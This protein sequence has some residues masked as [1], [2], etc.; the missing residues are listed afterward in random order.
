MDT[1]VRA[2]HLENRDRLLELWEHSA[3]ATHHVL[4]EGDVVAL[5][6][7]VAAEVASDVLARSPTDAGGR[8]LLVGH[9]RRPVPGTRNG[10]PLLPARRASRRACGKR[11]V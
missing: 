11:A 10:P 4:A 7:L 2:A 6:P 3:R 8:L 5:R 9:K 1:Y